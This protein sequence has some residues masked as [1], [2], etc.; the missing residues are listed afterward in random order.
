MCN[1]RL[2]PAEDIHPGILAGLHAASFAV[3]W[4]EPDFT[5]LFESGASGLSLIQNDNL[6]GAVLWRAA[7]DEAEVL[8]VF[9]SPAH[10]QKSLG[11]HLLKA[12]LERL[13]EAMIKK[14]YLEVAEDNFP[15]LQLYRATGFAAV[16]RRKGYYRR[17][18]EA[19]D[20]LVL[21]VQLNSDDH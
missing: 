17:L 15:A 1:L 9:V 11:R 13:A 18:H 19:V 3:P 14:V 6:L 21:Q 16:G 20:A 5:N 12:S 10:R 8:T 7:A 4:T 2:S